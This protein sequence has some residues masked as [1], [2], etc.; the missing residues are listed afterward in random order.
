M[1]HI[2]KIFQAIQNL[3]LKDEVDASGE[4]IKTAIGMFSPQ[5]EYVA[6]EKHAQLVGKV[7]VWLHRTIDTMRQALRDVISAPT[8]A[9]PLT[10]G[11]MTSR[12]GA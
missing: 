6:F 5:K 12:I 1:E 10:P 4:E 9:F 7:E 8:K 3:D 11:V 2:P